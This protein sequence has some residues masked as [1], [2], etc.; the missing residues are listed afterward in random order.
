[1]IECFKK[2]KLSLSATS[3]IRADCKKWNYHQVNVD[4]PSQNTFLRA[5]VPLEYFSDQLDLMSVITDN[6]MHAKV[7][8][9]E[10]GTFYNWHSDAYRYAPLNCIIDGDD[11][12]MVLFDHTYMSKKFVYFPT[13]RLIYQGS[14]FYMFNSQIPHCAFN[15]G[16]TPRYLLSIAEYSSTLVTS[17]NNY[18]PFYNLS[19]YLE[20]RNLIDHD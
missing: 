17:S 1:M 8:L 19:N 9:L 15:H 20:E 4:Y 6:N 2:L 13:T 7:F 18:E 11:D 12:Y 10:P 16:N 5:E 14:N 3:A